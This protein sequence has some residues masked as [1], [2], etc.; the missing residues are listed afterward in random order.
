MG[1]LLRE[2]DWSRHGLG[3]PSD[4]PTTLKLMT[5]VM[6]GSEQPVEI[7]WG[8]DL[9]CLYNDAFQQLFDLGRGLDDVGQPARLL[10]ADAWET[11]GD[12]LEGVM[13]DGEAHVAESALVPLDVDGVRQ[14][15]YWTYSYSPIHLDED[16]PSIGGIFVTCQDRT[17]SVMAGKAETAAKEKAQSALLETHHRVKNNLAVLQAMVRAEVRKSRSDDKT[18][19]NA[20]ARLSGRIDGVLRLYEAM[21]S[22]SQDDAVDASRY[23]ERLAHDV[24]GVMS[25]EDKIIDLHLDCEPVEMPFDVVVQL[26]VI[27]V[28]LLTNAHK[29]AFVG[30]AT[31]AIHVE[32]WRSGDETHLVVRDRRGERGMD[33]PRPEKSTGIGRMVLDA[34][35]RQLSGEST[36]SDDEDGRTVTVGFR[37]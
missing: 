35:V 13:R 22:Q 8:D 3:P 26:G 29:H 10:W 15:R 34:A 30:H 6:L 21:L 14:D 18:L 16:P 2:K 36:T 33:E 27:L 12:K 7:L 25:S 37:S 32:L 28:E 9:H 20:L 17:A 5:R 24:H 23:T 4:R 1:R 31:G 19:H 11:V